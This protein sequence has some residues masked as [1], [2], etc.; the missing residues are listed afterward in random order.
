VGSWGAAVTTGVLLPLA[1]LGEAAPRSSDPRLSATLVGRLEAGA[2]G[3]VAVRWDGPEGALLDLWVDLDGD[4]VR[5]PAEQVAEGRPL[6]PGI[7]VV[8]FEVAPDANVAA[9]PRAWVRARWD[10]RML[11]GRTAGAADVAAGSDFC[12]WQPGFAFSELDG[13]VSAMA[14]F[15]DGSG[16][17]LYAG[18]SFATAGGLPSSNIAAWSVVVP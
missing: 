12:A 14:V 10:R 13:G 8:T 4:G 15:D 2:A 11:A 16:P 1:C 18:G 3:R 9:R 6:V 5:C 7:E 17:A